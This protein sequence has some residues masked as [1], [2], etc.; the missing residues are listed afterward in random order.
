MKAKIDA[1]IDALEPKLA[2]NVEK[3]ERKVDAVEKMVESKVGAVASKVDALTF[4]LNELLSLAKEQQADAG[5]V[6]AHDVQVRAPA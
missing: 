4:T 5:A 6:V 1:K 3:V 2:A